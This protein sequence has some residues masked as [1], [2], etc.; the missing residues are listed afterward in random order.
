MEI[1]LPSL[2]I[3]F[4]RGV[5]NMKPYRINS[6]M[7]GILYLLGTVFG[8]ISTK[9]GGEVIS[10]L[11]TTKPMDKDILIQLIEVEP[12]RLVSGAFFIFLMGISLV[13]MTIFL[14]PIFKK[15]SEELA[16]GMILF[17][18]ALEGV[19]YF[20]TTLVFITL[21]VIGATMAAPGTDSEAMGNLASLIYHFQDIAGPLGTLFFLIGASCLYISFYRTR[22]IPRWLSLWGLI[23]VVPYMLYAVLHIFGK[24]QEFGF[25][26][27]MVLAPQEMVMAG[28][29]IIKGF[30]HKAIEKFNPLPLM[31]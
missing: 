11:V 5:Y 26:L 10:S 25:Y 16:A 28:W 20:V 29:L 2:M 24:D 22:L 18:G 1:P 19:W 27:Q 17:R 3:G 14:Y 31:T 23:G 6:L 13:A 21:S 9:A 7:T 8:I 30:N 12:S 15:D 4:S